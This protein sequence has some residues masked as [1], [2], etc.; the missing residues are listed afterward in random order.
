MK[1][2]AEGPDL[3]PTRLISDELEC[4]DFAPII[5]ALLPELGTDSHRHTMKFSKWSNLTKLIHECV[6]FLE[7]PAIQDWMR[8]TRDVS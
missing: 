7:L 2:P 1:W 8:E 4:Q 6:S 3:N 5:N